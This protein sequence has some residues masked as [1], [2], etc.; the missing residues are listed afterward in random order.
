MLFRSSS[1]YQP[2]SPEL[3]YCSH[4]EII[5]QINQFTHI[6]LQTSSVQNP[7]NQRIID[8]DIKNI[9]DFALASR[10]NKRDTIELMQEYLQLHIDKKILI[11]VASEGF[12]ERLSKIFSDFNINLQNKPLS[13]ENIENAIDKNFNIVLDAGNGLVLDQNKLNKILKYKGR[14]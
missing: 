5:T 6:E 13:Y 10:A 14:V 8:V 12:K 1:S 7:N 11:A 4:Q 3:L 2:I 9:P